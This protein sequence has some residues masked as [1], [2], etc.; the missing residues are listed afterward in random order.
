MRKAAGT[1]RRSSVVLLTVRQECSASFER[2][3]SVPTRGSK[4]N[5]MSKQ[6]A[7]GGLG[8]G[9]PSFSEVFWERPPSTLPLMAARATSL[10]P[11]RARG[12][13]PR[14][15]AQCCCQWSSL[16]SP[17]HAALVRTTAGPMDFVEHDGVEPTNNHGELELR[18]FV[19]WRK[20]SFG[21]QSEVAA[22]RRACDDRGTDGAEAGQGCARLP[23]PHRDG[24]RARRAAAATAWQ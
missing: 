4:P 11:S 18:E 10:P 5:A 19:L 1:R 12:A 23:G 13:L 7:W 6:E 15:S 17:R 21:S 20:R 9:V 3:N 24:S 2:Q 16:Q 14:C 22:L 8:R